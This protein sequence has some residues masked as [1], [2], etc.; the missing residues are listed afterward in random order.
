[1]SKSLNIKLK[2]SKHKILFAI[3]KPI[4]LH[5]L[6][7]VLQ[8]AVE[9]AIKQ[10]AH[11]LDAIIYQIHKEATQAKIDAKRNPDP[12]NLQNIYQRYMSA[13]QQRMTQAKQKKENVQKTLEDKKFNM[14]MTKQDSIFP[15]IDL[16]SGISTKAT[17]YKEFASKGDR[18]ESP[19][20]GI[21]KA[22]ESTSIPSAP[23]ITRKHHNTAMPG[24]S[25]LTNGASG[26]GNGNGAGY[27]SNGAGNPSS[28]FDRQVDRAFD[29]ANA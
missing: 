3:G 22:K 15:N 6:K 24:K 18:W 5:A 19:V 7:P 14:A 21:G 26:I 8:K 11:E 12:E 28:G 25:G 9:Q 17:E 10:K 29:P 16:P 4:I 20:F 2:K 23:T 1:L 27:P 13:A